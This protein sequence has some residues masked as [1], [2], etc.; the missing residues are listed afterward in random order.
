MLNIYVSAEDFSLELDKKK[1]VNRHQ[2]Y[3]KP[4]LYV[5]LFVWKKWKAK[6]KQS[7]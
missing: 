4:A 5:C 7:L 6:N 1:K 2:S 3:L